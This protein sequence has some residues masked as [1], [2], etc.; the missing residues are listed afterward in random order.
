MYNIV[1]K[2]HDKFGIKKLEYKFS[3]T[4]PSELDDFNK[5]QDKFVKFKFDHIQEEVTELK[6]AL[7][8]REFHEV[9]DAIVD[10]KWLADGIAHVI[11]FNY[12]QMKFAEKQVQRANMSKEL[13]GDAKRS[14]RGN[15]MDIIK[16]EGW[17]G[18]DYSNL[19]YIRGPFSYLY[20][21][22]WVKN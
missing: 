2:F 8:N 1:K 13:A 11:G 20:F 12:W 22:Y 14:K 15:A 6:E 18:P 3:D 7:K 9:C 10:I 19:S 17:V 4:Y 5:A 16:P 21:T